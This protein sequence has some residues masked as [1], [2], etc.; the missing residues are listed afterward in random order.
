MKQT[1]MNWNNRADLEISRARGLG[2]IHAAA[3]Y[4]GS[5]VPSM[6]L[7]RAAISD[8]AHAY[9]ASWWS[10]WRA[11]CAQYGEVPTPRE[12]GYEVPFKPE[13]NRG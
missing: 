3:R 6:P 10:E 5:E 2:A 12:D 1:E 9:A 7:W 11:L 4:S 8:C 13:P